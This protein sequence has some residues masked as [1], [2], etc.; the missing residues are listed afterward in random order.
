MSTSAVQPDSELSSARSISRRRWIS[1][2]ICLA[3][4]GILLGYDT[5]EGIGNFIG[6]AKQS[7]SIGLT[8]SSFG[9]FVIYASVLAPSLIFFLAVVVTLL[10]RLRKF[11]IYFVL[12]L[13]LSAILAADLVLGTSAYLI[14]SA[15]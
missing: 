14:F 4:L 13:F 9:V 15:S 8:L 1:W 7:A 6:V 3:I 5:W 2:G 12:A 11:W 10:T